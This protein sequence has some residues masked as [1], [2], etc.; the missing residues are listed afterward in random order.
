MSSF[1]VDKV[2]RRSLLIYSLFGT[3]ISLAIAGTYFFLQEV[4]HV[5]QSSLRYFGYIPF[6][7]LIL[8]N[9]I[10]TVGFNS[11]IGIIH[12]EIF[13]L[14]VKALA[15]TSL[16]VFGGFLGFTVAKGYQAVKNVS[17]LY[18]VLW[19]FSSI[20]IFGAVFTYF[21]VPETRGKSLREIQDMLNF[22]AN[23]GLDEENRI[24][25]NNIENE[26]STELKQLRKETDV[27]H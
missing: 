17:G 19:I 27:K 20:A 3:G 7:A 9:V 21:T 22:G 16:N 26:E 25:D 2:G 23:N 18:G 11:I 14:N 15:M 12:A 8:S 10:S 24:N 6:I 13:P 4:A 1:F 5:K